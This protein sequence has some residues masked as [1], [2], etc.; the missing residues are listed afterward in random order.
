MY[1]KVRDDFHAQRREDGKERE[2][3][4]IK[5]G[6]MG[7]V[8]ET[9]RDEPGLG[10]AFSLRAEGRKDNGGRGLSTMVKNVDNHACVIKLRV[11]T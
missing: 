11:Y 6:M 10:T 9:V 7:Q 8:S 1:W 2:S 5:A 3:S 4:G